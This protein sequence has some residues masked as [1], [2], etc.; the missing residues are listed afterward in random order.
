MRPGLLVQIMVRG[1]RHLPTILVP[2]IA[3]LNSH[4][5]HKNTFFFWKVGISSVAQEPSVTNCCP[6][7]VL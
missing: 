4:V 6:R 7:A 2:S 1:D 3:I 5:E